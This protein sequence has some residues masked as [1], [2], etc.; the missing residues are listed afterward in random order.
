VGADGA[1]WREAMATA[2]GR[3][4]RTS[5]GEH[6][7]R[8][9]GAVLTLAPR[10][11][12]DALAALEI[13]AMQAMHRAPLVRADLGDLEDALVAAMRERTAK[14]DRDEDS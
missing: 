8:I 12:E 1:R 7:P 14:E 10:L 3:S 4:A 6:G 11:D 5:I 9:A 2:A 13:L